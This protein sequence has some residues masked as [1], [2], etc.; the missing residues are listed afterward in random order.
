M[1]P[2]VEVYWRANTQS[3]YPLL[4]VF[5]SR[6]FLERKSPLETSK[7][8]NLYLFRTLSESVDADTL[9]ISKMRHLARPSR[10]RT[11]MSKMYLFYVVCI[12]MKR[13][14]GKRSLAEKF[15]RRF[16]DSKASSDQGSGLRNE[17]RHRPTVAVGAAGPARDELDQAVVE[18]EERG[19]SKANVGTRIVELIA[20][21]IHVQLIPTDEPI[22]VGQN[23]GT[24]GETELVGIEALACP[25][26]RTAT[27]PHAEL[28]D[29]D[30]DITGLMLGQ[31]LKRFCRASVNPQTIRRDLSVAV[32]V[33][34]ARGGDLLL[35][36][37]DT[38]TIA[39][40]IVLDL[41]EELLQTVVRGNGEP[42]LSSDRKL[43]QILRVLEHLHR[44]ETQDLGECRDL[45]LDR[46]GA[47]VL[48]RVGVGGLDLLVGVA[49][50]NR[51]LCDELRDS[52]LQFGAAFVQT[53]SARVV[54]LRLVIDGLE[55]T[56]GMEALGITR[57]DQCGLRL[58]RH[59]PFC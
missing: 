38:G 42:P 39:L 1:P 13:A 41:R 6:A 17:G 23:D 14:F 40:G 22:G 5:Y 45:I 56:Q 28:T 18:A 10:N 3:L 34:L 36:E 50:G 8:L 51:E 15:A 37:P 52:G 59:H 47:V 53:L 43:R 44:V 24:D 25:T 48:V 21:A 32:V 35:N 20:R 12:E 57:R 46:L 2:E 58:H 55:D 49:V 11:F 33:E 19:A 54:E 31:R 16:K 26:D 9:A 27:M 7:K 4:P 29:H 30:E